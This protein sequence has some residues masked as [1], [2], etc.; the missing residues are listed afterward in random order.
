[1]SDKRAPSW[2]LPVGLFALVVV[3]VAV[4]LVREPVTLDPSSPEGV[5]QE[6]LQAIHD[7]QWE[8]ALDL[9]HPEW[10]G[11]CTAEEIE[12]YVDSDFSAR[13][14][15]DEPFNDGI[16]RFEDISG[17]LDDAPEATETIVVTIS[18]R[19]GAGLGSS[20]TETVTF[21]LTDESGEWLIVGDPWPYF[22]WSCREG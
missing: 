4:A 2:L 20:W 7:E 12:V 18:H 15:T 1:M 3:L 14:G 5:V 17:A 6:Y 16:E 22:T 19:S 8:D 11:A 9:V 13:L 21:G 10:L